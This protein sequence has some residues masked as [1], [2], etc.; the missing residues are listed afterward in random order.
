VHHQSVAGGYPQLPQPD[1][2]VLLCYLRWR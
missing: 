1:D 2:N